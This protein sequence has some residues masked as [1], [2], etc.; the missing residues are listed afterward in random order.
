MKLKPSEAAK[1]IENFNSWNDPRKRDV[2]CIPQDVQNKMRQNNDDCIHSNVT[3]FSVFGVAVLSPNQMVVVP[4]VN[5]SHFTVTGKSRTMVVW[6]LIPHAMRK[7]WEDNIG[8]LPEIEKYEMNLLLEVLDPG[9]LDDSMSD[10]KPYMIPDQLLPRIRLNLP[11]EYVDRL[12]IVESIRL[13]YIR[14]D[15]EDR[16]YV[17]L[18]EKWP[19]MPTMSRLGM[20]EP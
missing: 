9:R 11:T 4:I 2:N 5:V 19:V 7:Y 3:L 6:S 12:H 8:L 16:D 15:C 17:L 14:E 13:D 1:F 20:P 18:N 10:T